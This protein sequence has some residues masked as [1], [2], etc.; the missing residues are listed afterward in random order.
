MFAIRFPIS[1]SRLPIPIAISD[2]K[3]RFAIR[4]DVFRIRADVACFPFRYPIPI[5]DSENRYPNSTI[6]R[7][8]DSVILRFRDFTISRFRGFFRFHDSVIPR[9][10]FDDFAILISRFRDF[11]DGMGGPGLRPYR[12]TEILVAHCKGRAGQQGLQVVSVTHTPVRLSSPCWSD[13]DL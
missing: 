3:S 11:S 9:L 6:P 8:R 13:F 10:R 4:A 1:N 5:R 12:S 2:S 7:F